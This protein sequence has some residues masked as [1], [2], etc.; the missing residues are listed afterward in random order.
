MQ[1]LG[2]A[3]TLPEAQLNVELIIVLFVHGKKWF[4]LSADIDIGRLDRW[5]SILLSWVEYCAVKIDIYFSNVSFLTQY[6]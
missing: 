3:F 6:T 2:S 1:W 5:V 4:I